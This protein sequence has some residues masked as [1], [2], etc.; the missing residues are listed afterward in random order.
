LKAAG[1]SL[2]AKEAGI[3]SRSRLFGVNQ[4]L[5]I[6]WGAISRKTGFHFS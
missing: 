1:T 5:Q 2:I 3:A 6:T 4:A